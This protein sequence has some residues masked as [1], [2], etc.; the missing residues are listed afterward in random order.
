MKEDS[1]EPKNPSG[2]VRLWRELR[3]RKV[4]RVASVYAV[5]GW[6]LIQIA[7][8]TFESFGI[9]V[10]AFR[11]VTLMVVLGFPIS[12]IIAWAFEI[13]PEGIVKT[14]L[15]SGK[16]SAS[17]SETGPQKGRNLMA[18]LLGAAVPTLIFGSLALVFYIR[19]GSGPDESG[20]SL[21]I[22]VM[23][24]LNMSS[25]EDNTFFAG[26]VHE[27]ILTNLSRISGL[28]VVSRTS[29]MRYI[30]SDKSLAE[31]ANDLGV[32]YIVEGSVRRVA[33]HVRVTVQL[34]DAATDTHLWANNYDRELVDVFATQSAVAKQ[35]SDSIHL[36]IQPE[37]VGTLSDMPTRSVKAY[38]LYIKAKGIDRSEPESASSMMRMIGLLEQAVQID[39]DF[40]EA[41]GFLNEACDHTIRNINQNSFY[42]DDSEKQKA[43]IAELTVKGKRALDKAIALDPNNLETLLAMA[44]DSVAEADPTFRV[45]RKRTLDRAVEL[46]PDDAI[47]WYTIGWWYNLDGDIDRANS[48]F[49]KALELDPL[50]ARILHGS[51]YHYRL[52][53]NREMSKLVFERLDSSL[54]K[55]STEHKIQNT[56]TA[57]M[58]TADEAFI[59]DLAA[60]VEEMK[61]SSYPEYIK[62]SAQ[63]RVYALKN[64]IKALTSLE[65][66]PVPNEGAS[67]NE[68]DSFLST[69][70]T[71]LAAYYIQGQLEKAKEI[72][73]LI[74]DANIGAE[75]VDIDSIYM[76]FITAHAHWTLGEL[77]RTR[78]IADEFLRKREEDNNAYKVGIYITLALID[79]DQAAKL[80]V[81]FKA[82]EPGWWGTDIMA[83]NY[84]SFRELLVH[85][86]VQ[87]FYREEGKWIEFLSKRV[88]EYGEE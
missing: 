88:P 50:H 55:A 48:A 30:N 44:S 82:Q 23:P 54:G 16:G 47:L 27:D 68:K 1:P 29:A 78:S 57:L 53:G 33:D 18:Y 22:A 15:A 37:T 70:S 34:V 72:A 24:L 36:E 5:V 52:Q 45:E 87:N 10:W 81:D 62:R 8:T 25:I 32:R 49:E 86:D 12:L 85:P 28:Q 64:D 20:D 9:P 42:I 13:T 2:V 65:P 59:D 40:V 4:M 21:S 66:S 31:I 51:L 3:R 19:S 46:Y 76:D 71:L 38:D 35:I 26:G 6:L 63:I 43:E 39:P 84:L 14:Q 77:E 11:F 75:P 83:M 58:E 74:L 79:R 56:Y 41:W 61:G 7:A 73:R 17:G 67:T 69:N 80:F 60:I